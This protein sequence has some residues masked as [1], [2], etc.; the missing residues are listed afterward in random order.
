LEELIYYIKINKLT[1]R[2]DNKVII[3]ADGEGRT[4][5]ESEYKVIFS[6]QKTADEVIKN[7]V[8]KEKNK[9][10]VY[11]VS[12]DKEIISY[13]KLVGANALKVDEFIRKKRKEIKRGQEEKRKEISY[14][15]QREITEELKKIWL[16]SD[17][18]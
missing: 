1:G 7:I 15:L 14:T 17:E 6:G 9:K 5:K 13:A 8:E 16:S 3:V 2:K 4:L 10:I 11:I 12:D 18:I